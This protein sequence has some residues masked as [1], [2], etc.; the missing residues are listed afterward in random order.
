MRTT[1]L[2]FILASTCLIFQVCSAQNPVKIWESTFNGNLQGRDAARHILTDDSG[3]VYITGQSYHLFTGGNFS[4]IKYSNAGVQQWADHYYS[5]QQGYENTGKKLVMDKWGFVYAVGTLSINDGDLAV[6][7]FGPGGR[8]WT[9]NY[10][11]Y[12]FSTYDDDGMD[13]AVDDSGYFY[14]IAEVTSPSGNLLDLYIMKCDSSGTKLWEDNYTGAS[15]S[16]YPTAIA[17]SPAGNAYPVLQSFNF[18]GT[19]T[20]DIT[21]IHYTT[22]GTQDW[23]SR[24]N[25]A[26]NATD[27]PT[28]IIADAAENTFVCGTADAGA[29]NDLVAFKQNQYGTRLW[30]VTYNGT[31]NGNDTAVA[32]R[33]LPNGLVAITGTSRELVGGIARNA[34]VTMVCDS[35]NVLWTETYTGVTGNGAVCKGMDIDPYGNIFICGYETGTVYTDGV[36]LKYDSTGNLEWNE[37]YNGAANMD[38]RFN[39]ICLDDSV[40]ILVT[41]SAHTS[42]A[43]SDYLTVKY[44]TQVT[45][46]IPNEVKTNPVSVY[47][48]PATGSISISGIAAGDEIRITGIRGELAYRSIVANGIHRLSLNDLGLSEGIYVVSVSNHKKT[49]HTKLVIQ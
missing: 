23:F 48:N 32:I 20:D 47:P 4:T 15:A 45:I 9:K 7:K 2:A 49:H 5:A 30:T 41:G 22:T 1:L 42:A 36:I 8:I 24:Y 39:S 21:T 29:N 12:W 43:N 34:I 44:G 13:I 18:F 33:Y 37:I 31:G 6:S 35:G 27:Y 19:T 17:V 10:E 16:D 46:G 3:N 40:N 25:G 38:D 26:G 28:S 11:P 14:A